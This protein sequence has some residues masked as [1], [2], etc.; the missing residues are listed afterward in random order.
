MSVQWWSQP[1]APEGSAAAEGIVKQLGRP[2]LDPLTV[3]VREAAQNSWDARTPG[4][5]VDFGID[6]RVLGQDAALWRELL[7]PGPATESKLAIEEVLRP[8]S[9]VV[10][11]SDR[12]TAGLGGPLRAGVKADAGEK[13]DFVQFLRNVGE[14][15]DHEF[16][17]G[18]Y[19]F[20]K[21]IFY[22]LSR[23]GAILVDTLTPSTGPESRRLMGAALGHSWYQGDRR[24]TGRHWWGEVGPDDV[25]DPMV[26]DAAD[27][28]SRRLGLPGFGD[29]RT[30]TDIVVLGVDLGVVGSEADFRE[31]T[32]HEAATFL[33]SSILWNLW[34]KL[35]PDRDGQ[36]MRFAVGVQGSAEPVPSPDRIEDLAPFVEALVEV[37]RDGGD[38]Y[39]RT[40]A[41]RHAG[42]MALALTSAAGASNRQLVTAAR[43]FSGPS[44]HVARMR[45][46]EL[47]VDYFAGPPHPDPRLSY[48]GV[49]RASEDA[50]ELFAT[51]EPP[52]HDDWVSKGLTGTARGVVQGARAFILR[53]IDERFAT[54]TQTGGTS[55]QGLG[56][57]AARLASVIPARA[58]DDVT[59]DGGGG[60]SGGGGGAR[61]GRGRKA[62]LVGSPRLYIQE[63]QPYLVAVV[64]VPAATN[65]RVL[66]V[67][68]DVVLEGGGRETEAPV[69]SSSPRVIQWQ[70]AD[71]QT[72]VPGASIRITAGP[73]SD[74]YVLAGHVPDAV[75][76][77]RVSQ[78]GDVG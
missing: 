28:V 53:R 74:W 51:A 8:D 63:G 22:R 48:A 76:R 37:R 21:G 34:P 24:Y 27:W 64:S 45:V 40:V 73:E 52:T 29:G 43:P 20:G 9:V 41:P 35:V 62:R 1:F 5:T 39:T 33:T 6:I 78:E 57:L 4:R 32:P 49:F 7:L 17:G 23:A 61:G 2:L 65:V 19:G 71:G 3:L 44:H 38:A 75:V 31:R 60:G 59:G 13:A 47:V 11:V 15:S 14:P 72:V 68:V 50:D 58:A 70:S 54:G 77:F 56:Q 69:G 16:G 25:P 36:Q 18:T 46:A 66:T 42:S 55:G 26:G 30:G 12:N 67:D 10:V